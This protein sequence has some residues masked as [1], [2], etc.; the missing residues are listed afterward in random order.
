MT[1]TQYTTPRRIRVETAHY[2]LRSI[3]PDDVTED[4]CEWMNDP[5]ASQM[6]NERPHRKT[7]KEVRAY[8]G[9]FNRVTNHILGIFEKET[10]R[11]VGIRVIHIDPKTKEY[12][13]NMMI[14]EAEARH[15]GARHETRFAMHNF[16]FEELGM[17]AARCTVVAENKEMR[18]VLARNG[19]VQEKTSYKGRA[20]GPG[21]VEILSFR[22]TRE[23]WRATQAEKALRDS[24]A[25]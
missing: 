20:N 23:T 7:L 19:W 4:F 12:L 24:G 9:A 10:D 11:L 14:G 15:K 8:V 3:D 25:E 16:M 18:G 1:A 21:F 13:V 6:L 5:T 2:V 17:E 22:M